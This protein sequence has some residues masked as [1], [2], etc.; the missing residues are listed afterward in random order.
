MLDVVGE[1]M[2][3]QLRGSHPDPRGRRGSY[4]VS[5]EGDDWGEVPRDPRVGGQPVAD[6]NALVRG[7]GDRSGRRDRCRLGCL[8]GAPTR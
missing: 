4:V 2:G 7:V 1:T 3:A 6:L 8:G 5:R